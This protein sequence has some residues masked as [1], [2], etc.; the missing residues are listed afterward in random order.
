ML[1]FTEYSK[2]FDTIVDSV[3]LD[4]EELEQINEVLSTAARIKKKQDFIRRKA[5]IQLAR[6]IQSRK[7]ATKDR[8]L[9]RAKKQARAVLIKRIF[10]G[11][12]RS[13]IPLAQRAVVDAR[14]SRMKGSVNRIANKLLRRVR[15]EDIARKTGKKLQKFTKT[16][17]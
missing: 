11:K 3:E 2:E 17:G 10:S 8:L 5:R 4:N 14:L 12:T 6:K 1:R 13:D 15:Q 16:A 9:I 7:F